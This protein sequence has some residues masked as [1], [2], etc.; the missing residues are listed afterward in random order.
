MV[1]ISKA[2]WRGVSLPYSQFFVSQNIV[3]NVHDHGVKAKLKPQLECP[4]ISVLRPNCGHSVPPV[5][6]FLEDLS[7]AFSQIFNRL[8]LAVALWYQIDGRFSL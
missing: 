4:Q 6:M 1:R 8:I 5:Q 3:A 7:H 2:Y